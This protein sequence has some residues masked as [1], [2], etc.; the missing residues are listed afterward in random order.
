M[1]SI[2]N[3]FRKSIELIIQQLLQKLNRSRIRKVFVWYIKLLLLR[4]IYHKME[5]FPQYI[6]QT[7]CCEVWDMKPQRISTTRLQCLNMQWI[8]FFRN[9]ISSSFLQMRWFGKSRCGPETLPFY[10]LCRVIISFDRNN[11]LEINSTDLQSYFL[12]L[13]V[14]TA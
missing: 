10:G 1:I 7:S 8:V 11:L 9:L 14:L 13:I 2:S 4:S 12:F 6:D 5:N 3:H